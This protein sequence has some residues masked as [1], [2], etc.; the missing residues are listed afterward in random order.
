MYTVIKD[1]WEL[2]VAVILGA[3]G[4]G[5]LRQRVVSLEARK[6]L[7]NELMTKTTCDKKQQDCKEIQ[8]L[9][10]TQTKQEFADLKIMIADVRSSNETQH[11]MIMEHLL[12]KK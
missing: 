9:N 10:H 2:V 12:E 6:H 3:V 7:C 8:T 4:Y 1:Y 5:S 11:N